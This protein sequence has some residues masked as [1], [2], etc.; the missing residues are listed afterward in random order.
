[1]QLCTDPPCSSQL[2]KAPD[3][4]VE[5]QPA[6]TGCGQNPGPTIP[7]LTSLEAGFCHT[8]K[9]WLSEHL[10]RGKSVLCMSCC[11]VICCAAH[12]ILQLIRADS[13]GAALRALWHHSMDLR[14][15]WMRPTLCSD[16]PSSAGLQLGL[17]LAFPLGCDPSPLP[18]A[19]Q[20]A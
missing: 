13:R 1:M 2:C 14:G 11:C 5:S 9:M 12:C 19:F 18:W 3:L 17:V 15:L 6:F 16:P 10:L 4:S 8:S 20:A 7:L